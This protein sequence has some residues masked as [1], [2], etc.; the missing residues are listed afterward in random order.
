MEVTSLI[1]HV[2]TGP[3][4][5]ITTKWGLSLHMKSE[6]F[7]YLQIAIHGFQ[8]SWV[9]RRKGVAKSAS[10]LHSSRGPVIAPLSYEQVGLR[11][12]ASC[13]ATGMHAS[14]C[15]L[16]AFGLLPQAMGSRRPPR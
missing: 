3:K 12:R 16:S 13:T 8:L 9:R 5:G 11:K 10:A 2:K 6:D 1:D 14:T 7:S 15:S 4:N